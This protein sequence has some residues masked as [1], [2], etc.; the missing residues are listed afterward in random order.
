MPDSPMTVL[1][2]RLR[3][4]TP[5]FL[6]DAQQDGRWR[7]PPIKA[8]LRQFW[9]MA[10]AADHGFNVDVARMRHEEGLLFGHAWL[11]DD[12]D[13]KGNKVAARRSLVRL[14]LHAPDHDASKA[15]AKGTQDGVAP[16]ST[17]L[18]T[19]YAWFGL[20]DSRNHKSRHGLKADANEGVRELAL[21]FPS[22]QSQR[23]RQVMQ[24]IAAFGTVGSRCRGAW[25]SI[26]V[27][28]SA[29][30]PA[31]KTRA[32]SECLKGD[33]A[34][35]LAHDGNGAC[36]WE[37]DRTFRQWNDAMRE[38]AYARKRIRTALKSVDGMDLRAALGFAANTGRM[39]SPLRWKVFAK[40]HNQLAI[41]VF[42]MPHGLPDVSGKRMSPRDLTQAWAATCNA[43][44]REGSIKRVMLPGL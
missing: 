13:A 44:D 43:L 11:K 35:A 21:A 30:L 16:L 2:Y 36:V 37:S 4:L 28:D 39:P 20:V 7:T 14:R 25:G 27:D 41:R 10:Y 1:R 19:S 29:E 8:L 22:D 3:M 40:Q 5:A 6:G 17:G 9:R 42:A 38:V 23:M 15:W 18:D 12:R 34:V 32:M 24:W 31:A 33:W 26:H